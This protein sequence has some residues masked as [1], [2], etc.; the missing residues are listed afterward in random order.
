MFSSTRESHEKRTR[1]DEGIHHQ[2]DQELLEVTQKG[3]QKA[4]RK[5]GKNGRSHEKRKGLDE[6]IHHQGEQHSH[7][8][9]GDPGETRRPRRED[10]NHKRTTE[11]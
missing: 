1:I 8:T 5:F 7:D 10:C 4:S 2:G 6:R 11:H 9:T 3:L